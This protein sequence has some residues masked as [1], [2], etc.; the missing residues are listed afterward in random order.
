MR[1]LLIVSWAVLGAIPLLRGQTPGSVHFTIHPLADGVYAAIAKNGGY[2]ICNAGI[3]DLGDE[4][5]IFDPFMSPIA[6]EDLKAAAWALTGHPVKYVVNSHWHNDH[7]GGNQ[8]FDHAMVLGTQVTHDLIAKYQPEEIEFGKTGALLRLEK[9]NAENTT[10]MSS[11]ELDEHTM[12]KGYFEAYVRSG[13]SLRMVLPHL[14]VGD[15]LELEG[16]KNSIQLLSMGEGHTESDLILLIPSARIAFT[17]DLLFIENQPWLGD[18]DLDKWMACLERIRSMDLA[19]FVPGHGRVG[20]ARDIDAMTGYIGQVRQDAE[21]YIRK[22]ESPESESV[23]PSPAPYDQWFLSK[24]YKPNVIYLY[25]QL[26][27]R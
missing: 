13:D 16:R 11:H 14:I 8:V 18:G 26:K 15:K 7:I 9:I 1:I 22:G 12:W 10:G 23:I 6:A 17:G 27:S 25:H 2:A 3:V 19:T 4:T 24:F 21:A 20:T 5:L